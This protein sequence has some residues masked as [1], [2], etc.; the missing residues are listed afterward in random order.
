MAEARRCPGLR[1]PLSGRTAARTQGRRK[2]RRRRTLG[3]GSVKRLND[4]FRRLTLS[5]LTKPQHEFIRSPELSMKTKARP[6]SLT[7]AS[8]H[9]SS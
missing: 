3:A 8:G 4:L 7:F 2:R 1:P 9:H 6:F 5:A